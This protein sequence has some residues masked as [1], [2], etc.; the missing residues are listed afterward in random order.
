[1][2][3]PATTRS[4]MVPSLGITVTDEGT[5]AHKRA[6]APEPTDEMLMVRIQLRQEQTGNVVVGGAIGLPEHAGTGQVACPSEADSGA[7]CI[8]PFQRC[9][10]GRIVFCG[11]LD[12]ALEGEDPLVSF[13]ILRLRL[14]RSHVRRAQ[15]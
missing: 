4:R 5:G 9:A 1:M 8:D 3:S 2:R 13:L 15:Q 7:R 12:C 11:K 6:P 14:C 10:D